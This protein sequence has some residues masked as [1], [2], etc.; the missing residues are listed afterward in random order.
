LGF[1]K[2]G[3]DKWPKKPEILIGRRYT[4]LFYHYSEQLP[5]GNKELN[6]DFSDGSKGLTYR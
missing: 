1:V 6:T 2:E 5:L 3:S 4:S